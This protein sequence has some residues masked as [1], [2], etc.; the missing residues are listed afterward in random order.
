M[1]LVTVA[2]DREAREI[3]AGAPSP[4]VV[5][6]V[7]DAYEDVVQCLQ[8]VLRHT[9]AHVD[10]LVVD[11]GSTD[12]RVAS[13]ATVVPEPLQRV[14]LW[15]RA[16]NV[17]FVRTMNDA[18][19]VTGRRDV[20][21]VNSDVIVGAQWLERLREAAHSD[22]RVA[23]ATPLTNHGT[24]LSV[25]ER[26]TPGP[27]VHGLTP[28]RAAAAVAA[29]S[30]RLR[31]RIPTCVGHC[32]YFKRAALD[33]VGGFDE[34]FSP[35]YGEEVDFSQR[36]VLSGMTHVVADD[37]FVFHRGG[38]S[39]GTS[40]ERDALQA[41]HERLIAERYPFYHPAVEAAA[42]SEHGPLAA[43]LASARAA[44][45]G[46]TVVVDAT[47][48]GPL[49]TGTQRT[50]IETV[51]ALARRP[52]IGRVRVVLPGR[53][54]AY[55]A[56]AFEG[57]PRVELV[58]PGQSLDAVRGDVV[59][60]PGQ[61]FMAQ[62]LALLRSLGRR[63][64]V[65]QLDFIAYEN[66]GYFP[67]PEVWRGYR[68]TTR[69]TLAVADG[70]VFLSRHTEG[71]ARTAGLLP[72]GCPTRVVYCGTDHCFT[73][74]APERP[75]GVPEAAAAGG[76]LLCFG[77]DFRHK[78]RLFALRV[79][80]RMCARGFDRPLVLAG[81]RVDFGSSR[82]AEA[83]YLLRHPDLEPRVVTL[84]E[85]SEA[86]RAWLYEHAGL[87]L[88]PTLHE[89]FGMVP[90]EAAAAG[91]PCLSSTAGSLAEILPPGID[92]IEDWDP[93]VVAERALALVADPARRQ[94]LVDALV[95]RGHEF[96]WDR[97]AERL[98]AFLLE[99][100]T[101]RRG[102][103]AV[104]VE[105]EGGVIGTTHLPPAVL[106]RQFGNG[107]GFLG[108]E[109]LYPPEFNEAM[110]AIGQRPALRR[111]VAGLAVVAYR[112]ASGVRSRLVGRGRDDEP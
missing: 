47:P 54:P 55:V 102:S 53:R 14:V 83:E 92:V 100:A 6:P 17:G 91:V 88:H 97:V 18:F 1:P 16:Q 27:L 86:E 36:C 39:F 60:R 23:T 80:A 58:E 9:A 95:R 65:N 109:D 13:L 48:L 66:P 10:V 85:V 105:G 73:P 78:N 52:G 57:C 68:D 22:G 28:G 26:N 4:V 99:V 8:A 67:D 7:H 43:S 72:D 87:V 89:G 37:V 24:I 69:L 50:V 38:A 104:A 112:I 76:F 107:A 41:A 108:I 32:T 90:F 82:P 34:V 110:R 103:A 96:T 94:A 62:E 61:V 31:P 19:A 81:P 56:G 63:V 29:R 12:P 46:L 20:V 35:G 77:T 33:V 42:G 74:A 111:P 25:P 98:E 64:V 11:D 79:F 75:A 15:R 21:L 71:E 59:Y 106:P 101:R 51:R 70:V 2:S 45:V 40:P 93:D 5:I 84:A 44:L 49:L 3:L 30:A